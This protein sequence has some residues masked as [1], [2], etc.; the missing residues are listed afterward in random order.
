MY[1]PFTVP[2]I[3][4]TG[5]SWTP[6]TSLGLRNMLEDAQESI[7]TRKS[8]V[9]SLGLDCVLGAAMACV[10]SIT[11]APSVRYDA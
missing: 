3:Y 8:L 2:V 1:I 7:S 5:V 9:A 6:D 11:F 4:D 10:P